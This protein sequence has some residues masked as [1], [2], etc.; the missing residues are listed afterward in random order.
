MNSTNPPERSFS[1]FK[2]QPVFVEANSIPEGYSTIIFKSTSEILEELN[3]L[4]ITHSGSCDTVQCGDAVIFYYNFNE[5]STRINSEYKTAFKNLFGQDLYFSEDGLL[6]I[7]LELPE[8]IDYDQTVSLIQDVV[9]CGGN[10]DQVS[11]T[12]LVK[13]NPQ[14]SRFS[15]DLNTALAQYGIQVNI[16]F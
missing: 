4:K 12:L 14:N 5:L 3:S 7:I 1:S 13:Y 2:S 6:S 8:S 9:A 11:G 15:I 10:V 16:Q